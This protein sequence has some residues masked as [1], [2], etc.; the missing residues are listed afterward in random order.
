MALLFVRCFFGDHAIFSFIMSFAINMC[1]HN[2][3]LYFPFIMEEGNFFVD[4]Y[5]Q[6]KILPQIFREFLAIFEIFF[7]FRTQILQL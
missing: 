2:K 4:N 5:I 3:K 1:K 6:V 7:I